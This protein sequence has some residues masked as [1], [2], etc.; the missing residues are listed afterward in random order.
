MA[1]RCILEL[2]PGP[3]NC[4]VPTKCPVAVAEHR[5]GFG[6]G[7]QF[8]SPFQ[9]TSSLF[10]STEAIRDETSGLLNGG[11]IRELAQQRCHQPTRILESVAIKGVSGGR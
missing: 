1:R 7:M 8:L 6:I 4:R 5:K 9:L 3:F 10:P 11:H 2:L